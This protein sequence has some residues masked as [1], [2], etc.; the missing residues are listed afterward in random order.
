MINTQAAVL[1]D[2]LVETWS[3]L[4]PEERLEGFRLLAPADADDFFLS[5]TARD[6]VSL[7]LS[8]PEGERRLWFRLLAPDDAA[9]V[10][11]WSRTRWPAASSVWSCSAPL[12]ARC[13]RLFYDVWGSTPPVPR[14]RS[15]P[16]SLM[17]PASSSILPSPA[18][19]S[20]GYCF[21]SLSR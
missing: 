15:L 17:S 4:S 1:Y 2:E 5:L 13:C 21:S 12:Q 7:L 8:L 6:Q 16:R 19:S 11:Y 14:R 20:V 9:D 18:L 3:L 10:T